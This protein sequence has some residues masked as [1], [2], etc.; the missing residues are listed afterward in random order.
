MILKPGTPGSFKAA[1][2]LL[3]VERI[4]RQYDA[5]RLRIA[6]HEQHNHARINTCKHQPPYLN[7]GAEKI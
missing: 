6:A 4:S 5:N 2:G 3:V 1:P 7:R